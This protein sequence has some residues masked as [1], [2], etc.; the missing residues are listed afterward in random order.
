MY[1]EQEYV[2]KIAG[3]IARHENPDTQCDRCGSWIPGKE[4]VKYETKKYGES[5]F[6]DDCSCEFGKCDIC[7]LYTDDN[8]AY[9]E[10]TVLCL[11]CR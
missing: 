2:K 9:E 8:A 5:Y 1:T 10:N 4:A 6:C 11:D 3:S 7:G